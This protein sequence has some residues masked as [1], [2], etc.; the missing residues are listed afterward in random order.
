MFLIHREKILQD[1][2]NLSECAEH[3]GAPAS[4]VNQLATKKS[5]S[6]LGKDNRMYDFFKKMEAAGYA[7]RIFKEQN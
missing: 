3:F 7:S 4:Y 5:H 6:F 2:R 1:F